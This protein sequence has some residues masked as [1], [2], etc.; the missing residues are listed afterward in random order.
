[1]ATR[2]QNDEDRKEHLHDLADQ[3]G[4]GVGNAEEL[5]NQNAARRTQELAAIN[6]LPVLQDETAELDL[7]KLEGPDGE[8]VVD[9]SVRGSG[10]TKGTVVIYEDESGRLH[11]HLAESTIDEGPSGPRRSSHAKQ[12]EKD[13]AKQDKADAQAAKS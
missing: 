12:A 1:V 13:K 6:D 7:D 8:Y 10:R 11:K 5:I 9:A 4:E 2:G 3:F